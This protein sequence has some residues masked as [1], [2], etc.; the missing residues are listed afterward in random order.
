MRIFSCRAFIHIP[1]DERLK[2]DSKAKQC[3]FMGYG[4]EE[5]GYSLW[6][7]MSKKIVN[8]KDQLVDDGDKVKKASSSTEIQLELI[9]LFYL[10][11]MIIM[12]R[13]TRR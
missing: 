9:Q 1:K 2:L 8:L 6:D 3:I 13:V 5:F 7:P 10:Q 4:D 12:G 11:C